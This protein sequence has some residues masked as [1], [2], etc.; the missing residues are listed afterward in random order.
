M[1]NF[2]T[3]KGLTIPEGV[4][5]QIARDGVVLWKLQTSKPVVLEVEKVIY[6]T[7]ANETIYNDEE[8][9]LLDIYPKTNGTV[10][11]TY[12]GLTKT[13]VDTSGVEEPN[14]Q[15][16][17]FGTFNGV[18]DSVATP[19]S[20]TLTIEGD[21]ESFACP[22]VKN[23]GKGTG[24]YSGCIISVTDYGGIKKCAPYMFS[25]CSKMTSINLP[26]N[27]TEIASNAFYG[28]TALTSISIPN[29]VNSIGYSAFYECTNLALDSLPTGLINIEEGAFYYC[30]NITIKEIPNGVRSIGA[31]A[32][33]MKSSTNGDVHK[34][35][36]KMTD[37]TLP[38]TIES[39]GEECFEAFSSSYGIRYI[40]TFKIL[41]TNP[42]TL[43]NYI[44]G[45][46]L[47][48]SCSMPTK[49]IVPKGC[50]EAYKNANIWSD[51]A[52]VIVEES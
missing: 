33:Y 28:C 52:K 4:V 21:C 25:G 46:E 47:G 7:Y 36:T 45:G 6:D 38:T 23:S 8:F 35:I 22:Y 17:F 9:I 20:G 2:A 34:P 18:S 37:I 42:P 19:T 30:E 24:N 51:Y 41:A 11:V 12:G 3:L 29:G 1:I 27:F 16:V 48:Q 39:I 50:G 44:F 32:F 31:R 49:I 5:T 15:R 14:A 43:D 13:I 26:E 10:N 40:N